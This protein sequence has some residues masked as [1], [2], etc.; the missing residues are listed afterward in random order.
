LGVESELMRQGAVAGDEV[1]IG[2]EHDAVVFDWEPMVDTGAE[3]LGPRG[4]DS[5]LEGR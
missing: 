2:P 1:V 5:R 3:R 4:T